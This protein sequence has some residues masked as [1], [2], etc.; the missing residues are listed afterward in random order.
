MTPVRWRPPFQTPDF[1]CV[2]GWGLKPTSQRARE[3]SQSRDSAYLA[4]EDGFIRSVEPGPEHS[5]LSL[6]MDHKGV[7]YDVSRASEFEALVEM[8]AANWDKKRL[9]RARKGIRKI[10]SNAISKYNHAPSWTETELGLDPSRRKGRVLVVDQTAGDAAISHGNASSD[11][12]PRMLEAAKAEN[13]GAEIVVKLH[14]EVVAGKKKGHFETLQ[15]PSVTMVGNEVNP[16]S[17]I[18]IVD[19]VYVVTSQLGFEALMGKREVICFGSPFYAGWG[20]TDDRQPVPRRQARP[21]LEQFFAAAYFDYSRYISPVTRRLV[22]FEEAVDWLIGERDRYFNRQ[23]SSCRKVAT[24]LP[25]QLM[26]RQT[27]PAL[28]AH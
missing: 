25:F 23:R 2:V 4:L 6:I 10:R 9:K 24:G 17:L 20:L 8:S 27:R 13:P 15:D 21:T 7:H 14:P 5:P 1:G 26:R 22:R 12:F 11:T 16:W 28:N 18:E 19:K 3:L